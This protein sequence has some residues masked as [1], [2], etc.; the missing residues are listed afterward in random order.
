MT[1][2]T[3]EAASKMPCPIARTFGDIPHG[4][5]RGPSCILWRWKPVTTAHPAWKAAV[6]AEAAKLDEKAPFPKAA[7][8]VA[9]NAEALGLVPTEGWCGLAQEPRT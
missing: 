4:T 8:I 7:R 1:Y 2:L 9:D 6:L 3:P 5:C